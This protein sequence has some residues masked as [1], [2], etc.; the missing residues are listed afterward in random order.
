MCEVFIIWC[1]DPGCLLRLFPRR[2]LEKSRHRLA[3]PSGDGNPR[4]VVRP[5]VEKL[6]FSLVPRPRVELGTL[7][8]SGECSTN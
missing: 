3:V 4:S 1:R 7:P 5:W 2:R 6:R 8:S